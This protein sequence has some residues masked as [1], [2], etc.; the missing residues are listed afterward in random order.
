MYDARSGD[1]FGDECGDECGHRRGDA[2]PGWAAPWS[3]GRPWRGPDRAAQPA[4]DARLRG[5]GAELAVALALVSGELFAR[6]NRSAAQEDGS[7]RARLVDVAVA[8][9]RV[10]AWA[11]GV[12]ARAAA[13]LHAEL[14]AELLAEHTADLAGG[15]ADATLS[16]SA[17]VAMFDAAGRSAIACLSMALGVSAV[18][19][20]KI[21]ALGR[22][23]SRTP[24]LAAALTQGRIDDRQAAVITD[25]TSRLTHPQA[26]DL[27]D[28]VLADP[29]TGDQPD[30]DQPGADQT[31][32]ETGAARHRLVR[33]LAD[34]A[35]RV[36]SIPAHK[37]R[38]ILDRELVT[39]AP[40]TLTSREDQ[41]VQDRRVT[42]YGSSPKAPGALVL[43]GPDHLL[44]AAYLQLDHTARTARRHGAHATLDQLRFDTAIQRMLDGAATFT[45]VASGATAAGVP[46]PADRLISPPIS[47]D[48]VVPA[49]MLVGGEQLEQLAAQRSDRATGPAVLRTPSGDV[50]ISAELARELA[51]SPN[52]T[53]RRIL[54]NPATGVAQDVSPRYQPPARMAAFCR[55]RDGHTS[56]QPTSSARMVEL[57]HITEYDHARPSDGGR[58]TAANLASLGK[59]DHQAKTDRIIDVTGD[60]NGVLSFYT[61]T[62]HSYPGPPHRF[63]DELEPSRRNARRDGDVAGRNVK[64]N[65][66][67]A[68]P[69][70]GGTDRGGRAGGGPDPPF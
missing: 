7:R 62:G 49:S 38:P 3:G 33:E 18:A 15:E 40:E 2:E 69:T 45:Q 46:G 24:L 22:S 56:R 28:T 26:A 57:D 10:K 51:H 54:T 41:A 31:E 35:V 17:G 59:R 63:H 66:A 34:G 58:T 68:Q 39:I 52:S 61:G 13:E 27:V 50:P 11:A 47:V 42:H 5:T 25:R 8:A 6:D 55:V 43:H 12:Q 53:W 4:P 23:L 48:V 21:L 29:D 67:D 44:A 64:T 16:S 60:A 14:H 37:L 30:D 1:E 65:N 32:D 36:W 19:A 70:V 9:E 20:D